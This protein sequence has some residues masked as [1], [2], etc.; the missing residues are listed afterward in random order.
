MPDH[1]TSADVAPLLRVRDLTVPLPGGERPYAVRD[2]SFDIARGEILCIVGESGSGK[3]ISAGAIMGLLPHHLTPERGEILFDGVDLLRLSET[4]MLARRG[5]QIGMIFQ[6]PM[7]ALNPTMR[8]G[9]QIAEVMAVHGT[10]PGPARRKRVLDLLD[11]VGL[12]DPATLQHVYPFRLSGGQRQRVVIAMAL[13]LEPALLIADEPTTALDVTTQA[14]ILALIK[15]IQARMGMGVM[16][17][18]HD[19][20]VVADIADRIAV[21]EKGVLVEQGRATEVLDSP[22]HPYTRHLIAAVPTGRAVPRGVTVEDAPLLAVRNL[23]KTYT[24]SGGPF[25]PKRVVP[26]VCDVSFEVRR[27]EALGIVGESGSGK[28]TIGKCLLKLQGID[29]GE[30]VFDGQDI[31]P[32]SQAAFRPQ[33]RRLQMIFQDPFASLNPR[34]TVGRILTDG[35][36]AGGEAR[37]EAMARARTL[38]D[39]VGL[40]ASALERYPHEFSGG[41]RQRVGIARALAL[42]PDLIVADESVSALDVS[43]QAQVLA[44]LKD[45]Q[46][47]LGVALVFITHDLRV[48]A[49]VCQR[50]AVMHRGCLVEYGPSA[51]VLGASREDYTRRLIEA[52]PGRAWDARR[53]PASAA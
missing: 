29:G 7:S 52:M 3:S 27:G 16:F 42:Q 20:G 44:L 12:P 32:L 50:I 39:L 21:M 41:Q 33:R 9:D 5:R 43:V 48:A 13:A 6:E 2:V 22:R 14:Q 36:V 17:I 53:Q 19:F 11:L 46:K 26:A 37:A 24:T 1:S 49:E 40:P 34:Q 8:I 51:E 38:L 31:A 10:H 18:T 15:R 25:R 47:R 45:L 28:S 35:P 4:E 30:I 23:I